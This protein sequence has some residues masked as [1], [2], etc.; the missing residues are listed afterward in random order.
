MNQYLYSFF[1]KGRLNFA[2]Q[3]PCEITDLCAVNVRRAQ[4]SESTMVALKNGEVRMYVDKYLIHVIKM[5]EP[6]NGIKFGVFGR[7]EGFL[8]MNTATGGLCAKVLQRQASF[9]VT[10]QRA[11]PPAEQDIP[12]N[13][14]KK[15]KLY[16][17]LVN[18][19]KDQGVKMHRQFQ[20]DLAK[21]R[22]R[23]AE[24]YVDILQEGFA[25]MSYSQGGSNLRMIATYEGIGPV[26]KIKLELQNLGN[27]CL[28]DTSIVLNFDETVYK[29]RRQSFPTVPLLLPQL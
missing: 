11:G 17:D 26:F 25:P 24:N 14:P 19:E 28:R 22:L 15:T 21:L 20:K 27:E 18:R 12:L 29:N 16:L 3:M 10:S 6:I 13:V 7:E 9:T 1:N 4:N 8:M 2:K 5:D 23:T